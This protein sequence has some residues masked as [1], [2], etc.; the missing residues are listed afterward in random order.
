VKIERTMRNE[1]SAAEL[2]GM[3]CSKEY[4][5]RKCI[6]AGALSYD[7]SI[8]RTDDG[9]VIRAKRKLPTV[10]FPSLLRKFVPSGVTTTEVV[11]W[12]AADAEGARVAN[13]SVDFHGTPASMRGTIRL[14]P[15]G[16]DISLI[17]V[18][19][20]FKA[21]VP[22]VGRKVEAFAAPIILGV[23]DAEEQT[24]KAWAAGIR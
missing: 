4:Q 23:I 24:G 16:A 15:S 17:V 11:T 21:H 19:A 5:E 13:L 2:F 6:D 7:V 12:G 9:A 18:D 8:A 14:V 1:I 20:D 10:G 3:V 22:L